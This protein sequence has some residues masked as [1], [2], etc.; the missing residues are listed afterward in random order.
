MIEKFVP[1]FL[2]LLDNPWVIW[3]VLGF[4]LGV[5]AIANIIYIDE[6]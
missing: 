2:W 1:A 5:G 3:I 6:A 4:W